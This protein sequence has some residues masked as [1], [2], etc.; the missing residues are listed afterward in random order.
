[1]LRKIMVSSIFFILYHHNVSFHGNEK[2]ETVENAGTIATHGLQRA[3]AFSSVVCSSE[4]EY[5]AQFHESI[6]PKKNCCV[7]PLTVAL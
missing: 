5:S 2:K 1:M 6:D 4:Q 7:S 3:K